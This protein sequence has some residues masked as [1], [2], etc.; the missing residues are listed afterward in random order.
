MLLLL[1][2]PALLP[3]AAA[4]PS[5]P[6]RTI[7][8]YKHT[9]WSIDEGAP[10]FV[11]ALA[12]GRD[13]FLW[14]GGGTGLFR[15]D[16]VAFEAIAPRQADPARRL[17][18]ALHVARDGAIWVGYDN[19]DFSVY[20]GNALRNASMT[21]PS[22]YVIEFAETSDGAIW[23]SLGRTDRALARYVNGAWREVGTDWG[24][25]P[26]WVIAMT[27]TRDG[28][29]WV[30]T[31]TAVL[32][33]R[34]GS[35]RFERVAAAVGSPAISQDPS[36]RIWLSD[37]GGSRILSP[38]VQAGTARTYPT[39]GSS[40]NF[41]TL[42]DRRGNLWG[43]G[44]LGVFRLRGSGG[45][46]R[47]VEI[48]RQE[49]GLTSDKAVPIIEDRE[50]NIW[51]GTSMGLDRFS[52]ANVVVEPT[53]RDKPDFGYPL[54][55]A[56]DGTVYIGTANA[57]HRVLPGK[58]PELLVNLQSNPDW[59]C[60]G[61]VGT[62]WVFQR[63]RLLRLQRGRMA[64]QPLPG[65]LESRTGILACAFDR[66][67]VLWAGAGRDG[68]FRLDGGS[69]RRVLAPRKPELLP[70][71]M[72]TG[73]DG[74]PILYLE[75][76]GL[77]R[78]D[79][80]G[81]I[82]ATLLGGD[83]DFGISALYQGRNALFLGSGRG[84]ARWRT[85]RFEWLSATRFPWLD[86]PVALIDTP[87]GGLWFIGPAGIVGLPLAEFDRALADKNR[88]L[89]PTILSFE[90]GLPNGHLVNAQQRIARGGDGRLWFGTYGG[91]VWVD[92]A[93]IV[94]NPAPPPV[95]ITRVAF[96][97]TMLRDPDAVTLKAGTSRVEIDYTA[98]S[99]T[100]PNRIAFRYRLEGVDEDWVDPGTRRQAFYTN[101]RPGTYR[102][103]VI[104]ANQDGVWNRT[105]A[106]IAI[107]LPPTF[108]QSSWF[109]LICA[110][111]VGG[112]IWLA[113]MLRL[114]QVTAKLQ[115]RFQIRI[116]ERER[117]AR[118]LHDTLLQGF[119][120][121]M[122]RFQTVAD[123]IPE[124]EPLRGS[125]DD[126]LDRAD[127]L[128]IEGRRR[129]RDLRG[130]AGDLEQALRDAAE[131]AIAESPI[132]FDLSVDGKRRDL[133]PLVCEEALRIGEEAIRNA[134]A[135]AGATAIEAVLRYDSAAF[136]LSIRDDGV[137]I[138]EAIAEAGARTGHFGLVGMKER[139]RR[140]GGTL[141][142]A[143]RDPAGAEIGLSV[144][145]RAAYVARARRF[146]F[147]WLQREAESPQ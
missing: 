111:A 100:I 95:K 70:T 23:A 14:I 119:Q 17:V 104:A 85:G 11:S 66:R 65:A 1:L 31:N 98:L 33:L 131:A 127:A 80:N 46:Q 121:L 60:E 59:I 49:D 18:T 110:I 106:S 75:A 144:P 63:D 5:G 96:A 83:P 132:R 39:P 142:I 55:G 12:Q 53:L 36:G 141:T 52:T 50:G 135:H 86:T 61:P 42:F 105:G 22:S 62:I 10:P 28:S 124:N 73:L 44:A 40:R 146:R 138:P 122:L 9:R 92:P 108:V 54:F 29:L 38:L 24:L 41:R 71:M 82:A 67:G 115:G 89:Q 87:E 15:F 30:T 35:R 90:D 107:H 118:E 117:I 143:G 94:R 125:I 26:D 47:E 4:A 99:L 102:F 2:L 27:A 19:G 64:F 76:D 97:D 140:I 123:R 58:A 6:G 21:R 137:G 84:I 103:Q 68:L 139:A 128:L 78:L 8:Q 113:Y 37:L 145:A 20:R 91:V 114:R 133:S 72:E 3:R 57:L 136:G 112:L 32:V 129:V 79:A 109:M 56:S 7:A 116:A 34:R 13:G 101:L 134:V 51:V 77:V 43:V 88:P 48:Y 45:E 120:G 126:A 130:D 74:N 147:P 81:G 93:H 69:W 25:P 16:G